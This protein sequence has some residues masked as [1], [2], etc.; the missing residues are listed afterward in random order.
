MQTLAAIASNAELVSKL[1][2]S[3]FHAEYERQLAEEPELVNDLLVFVNSQS[4]AYAKRLKDE[5]AIKYL[6]R[7]RL[8][9]NA[10]ITV[11]L[12]ARNAQSRHFW[13]AARSISAFRQSLP[14]RWWGMESKQGL[15]LSYTTTSKLVEMMSNSQPAPPFPTTTNGITIFCVDQCHVWQVR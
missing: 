15:L 4:N 9:L 11:L 10:A 3:N 12:K 1:W 7:I 6:Q 2:T 14:Q 13:L 8:K 5:A